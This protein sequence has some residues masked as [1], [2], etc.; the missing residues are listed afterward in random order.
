MRRTTAT[1]A[2]AGLLA[3]AGCGGDEET[4][5]GGA[6]AGGGAERVVLSDFA[7]EPKELTVQAGKVTFDVVNEGKAPHRL[8]IEG[9]G[10]ELAT[11]T[12]EGTGDETTLEADVQPGTYE[13]YCPIGQHAERGMKG[14]LTVEGDG[15]GSSGGGSSGG[16]SSGGAAGGY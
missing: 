4:D 15:G 8:E 13:W 6:P 16:G 12:L 11:E 2:C 5:G 9:Q 14:T 7:I 3:A 10:Q 1:L